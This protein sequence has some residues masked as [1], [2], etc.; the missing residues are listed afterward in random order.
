MKQFA[1]I[2]AF[3]VL[4]ASALQAQEKLDT[5]L[6]GQPEIFHPQGEVRGVVFLFS[7]ADG[8]GTTER[9]AA[10][11]VLETGAIVVGIDT[12][13]YLARAEQATDACLYLIPDF[14]EVS[15]QLQRA[16]DVATYVPPFV[17]G[18]GAGG[19]VALA[20]VAQTPEATISGTFAS[21]PDAVL[22]L[23]R[24]LCTQAPARPAEDGAI[25]G[26][27]P[28]TLP[29]PVKVAQ[30]QAASL[31]GAA[32]VR[33]LQSQGF[34]IKIVGSRDEPWTALVGL[35]REAFADQ[36]EAAAPLADPA[37]VE[38]PAQ[39]AFDTLAV[40]YS[41]DGGWRDIDRVIGGL[42]QKEG[43]P[44]IGVDSLRYF[45]T[46]RSPETA[47]HDLERII[48]AYSARWKT[49]KVLLVGYSFG[50]NVLPA[51]YNRLTAQMRQRVRQISLLG[52]ARNAQ[53]QITVSGWLGIDADGKSPTLPEI[54]KIDPGLIQCFFGA[55]EEA[56]AC[57]DLRGTG[58]Q[59]IETRGG[60]HFDGDY[61]ALARHILDGLQRRISDRPPG[62]GASRN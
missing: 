22:G 31:E 4:L 61:P 5:G 53:F 25:Y 11:S 14:E 12:P 44:T 51:I 56:S 9:M 42:I 30:T 57:K 39:P 16:A 17:A 58:A 59:L 34:A 50:A 8:W 3:L 37:L 36:L 43:V 6:L 52:L 24:P 29:D 35:L 60:H 27:M 26:F 19:A 48:E 32:H 45:W 41:G 23:K 55:D 40:I 15:Q 7:D 38:L 54:R 21:D 46:T 1:R 62:P 2:F 49:S 33:N 47:A 13:A 10:T 18:V 20:L 28:G